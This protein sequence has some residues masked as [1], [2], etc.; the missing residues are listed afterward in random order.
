MVTLSGVLEVPLFNLGTKLA[1]LFAREWSKLP[2]RVSSTEA[3]CAFDH[4]DRS[5]LL[6]AGRAG[7]AALAGSDHGPSWKTSLT[8]SNDGKFLS[9]MQPSDPLYAV[10]ESEVQWRSLLSPEVI[11][12]TCRS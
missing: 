1:R 2:F 9:L 7:D 12:E 5:L 6:R 11:A 4:V 10:G 8:Y 3:C